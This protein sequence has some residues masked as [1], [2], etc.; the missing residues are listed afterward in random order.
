MIKKLAS[1]FLAI[2][3]VLALHTPSFAANDT[4]FQKINTYQ[5]GQFSDVSAT[6]WYAENV[7]ITYEYGLMTGKSNNLFDVG[8]NLTVAEAVAIVCRLHNAYNRNNADFGAA[9]PWYQPYVDYA[10]ANGIIERDYSYAAPISRLDFAFFISNALPDAAMPKLNEVAQ[11]DIPDLYAGSP[12]QDAIAAL[13]GTGVLEEVSTSRLQ[14]LSTVIC[15]SIGTIPSSKEQEAV[16]RL[17]RAGILTGNDEHGTF[18]PETNITRSAA[19]AIVSRVVEPS[20]RKHI[21]LTKKAPELVPVS[22]LANLP[23]V[24]ERAS[25]EQFAL[26][27]EE[28]KR[29]VDPI[30]GLSRE[31]Q[32]CAIALA[33]RVIAE[34]NITYSMESAHY[35]DPYGFFVDHSASCAGCTRATGLCLNMLGIPYEHVNENAFSHQWTRVNVN[36]TYWICDAYGLYC[37]PEQVPY[38]HPRF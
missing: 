32:L 28:A 15:G 21:V 31:A 36:G 37:G 3:M 1:L 9:S 12:C 5:P 29:I 6:D 11:N 2:S 25:S 13:Q 34:K 17:Y 7:K 14:H 10:K 22:Q 35:A 30:R 8:G 20:L 24:K 26:A 27:Y 4:D 38:Q 16:Y 18:A 33:T 19:A 23:S